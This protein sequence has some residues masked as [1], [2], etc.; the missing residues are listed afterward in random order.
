MVMFLC[1]R[2]CGLHR[3]LGTH[4]SKPRS[5]D[6]DIWTP[7]SIRSAMDWGNVKGN[8]V[9][10]GSKP[11]EVVPTDEWVLSFSLRS[12]RL[13]PSSSPHLQRIRSCCRHMTK[14]WLTD[15][16]IS[17]NTSRQST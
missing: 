14:T 10:E 6:L 17:P 12:L 7:E 8:A 16:G 1:I 15:A 3:G 9:W 4:I 11:P 5:V 13:S 2:C